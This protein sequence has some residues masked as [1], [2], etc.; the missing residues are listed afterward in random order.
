M[1]DFWPIAPLSAVV[2]A[3]ELSIESFLCLE[4][5]PLLK[6]KYEFYIKPQSN[7]KVLNVSNE[8]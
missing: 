8:G 3:E 2:D 1:S 6:A 4:F 5:S 7:T